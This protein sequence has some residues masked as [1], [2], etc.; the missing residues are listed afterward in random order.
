MPWVIRKTGDEWCIY[1]KT[2]EGEPGESVACHPTQEEAQ[3]QMRAL[4]ANVPDAKSLFDGDVV[5][6]FGGAIKAMG[7]GKLGG[8]LV[9][10][11]TDAEPDL[12]GEYFDKATDFGPHT[13][14]QVLYQ[15]GMDTRL[16]R[17]VLQENAEIGTDDI[18]VWIRAQLSLRDKYEKYIYAEVDKGRMGWSSG[19]APHLVEYQG[20]GKARR[21]VAWPL[22][23]DASITP[24][25][26]EP[27][28]AVV[29]LKSLSV[30][31]LDMGAEEQP[32]TGEKPVAVKA[33]EPVTPH[34]TE[35][36]TTMPEDTKTAAPPVIDVDAISAA[37]Y[38]GITKRLADEPAYQKAFVQ[39]PEGRD[40]AEEKSL[41][42]F[43]VALQR[44]D[45]NRIEKVYKTTKAA[46]AE[47]SGGTGGY[48]VPPEYA[49][50]ILQVAANRS[51]VRRCNP[52]IQ[53]MV[54]REFDYPALD[55]SGST[56]G[57]FAELGGVYMTW[58]EEAASK[59]ETEPTF[60]NVKL[61][62]H[63]LSGYMKASNMLR[64]DAG[65]A[66]E[67]LIRDLFGK[68]IGLH[69]DWAFLNGTGAGQPLGVFNAN[70]LK[71]EVAATSSFVLS[72]IAN[73]MG[74]WIS[75]ASSP[76]G[77]WIIHKLVMPLLIQ[78]A[79][80]SG[81]SN[82]LIWMSNAK[83]GPGVMRLMGM[84]VYISTCM[85][86]MPP[87]TSAAT[88]GGVLL[89]DADYY[90]IGDRK[91]VA[92]DFSEHVGFLTNQGTWRVCSYVDG[93]P[94]LNAAPY[95]ADGSTTVSP[96]VTLAGA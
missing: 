4:Y 75:D 24:T 8:Y 21:I 81:A 76:S 3:A 64:Q 68:A 46:L 94:W 40:H 85:P 80:G 25:P 59:T 36:K 2:P 71:T 20:T 18:G 9:R 77:A 32:E 66:L 43:L 27:R 22:G 54:G 58:T 78:L 23:L 13:T 30:A 31:D 72:D 62:Y 95:L 60:T 52:R 6:A 84:P 57:R 47:G 55:V 10:F 90:I 83:D 79:D 70:C 33:L 17:R 92:I 29:P 67:T 89:W 86:L 12:E 41:A 34:D 61:I 28:N 7:G 63:E 69:E 5:V 96:F 74:K 51:V 93:Q 65:P 50:G 53:P 48:L 45:T 38:A 44:G 14:T 11:T 73:M 19:T 15:H 91:Q 16:K 42:D 56:K 39:A 35:R 88:K 1:K 82:N 37:I 26:A 87:G 49:P